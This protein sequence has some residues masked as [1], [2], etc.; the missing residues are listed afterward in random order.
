MNIESASAFVH[1][2]EMPAALQQAQGFID[3]HITGVLS[4]A[5]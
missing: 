4:A 3:D 1:G 5:P 2:C